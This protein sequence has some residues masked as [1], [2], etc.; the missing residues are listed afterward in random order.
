LT[1]LRQFDNFE[2]VIN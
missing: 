1:E 2:H